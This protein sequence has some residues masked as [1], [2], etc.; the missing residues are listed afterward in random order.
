METKEFIIG[1]HKLVV[2]ANSCCNLKFLDDLTPISERE[3][4]AVIDSI[5]V[6]YQSPHCPAHLRIE[7]DF[8]CEDLNADKLRYLFNALDKLFHGGR[9]L[10]RVRGEHKAEIWFHYEAFSSDTEEEQPCAKTI[11]SSNRDTK[12]KELLSVAFSINLNRFGDTA[13]CRETN[14]IRV[15]HK[16]EA[17]CQTCLHELA[18]LFWKIACKQAQGHNDKFLLFNHLVN[19]AHPGKFGY[20]DLETCAVAR[21]YKNLKKSRGAFRDP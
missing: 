21:K 1:I 6:F 9:L 13:R 15:R 20:Y 5:S 11:F 16:L 8:D 14:G 4:K 18:H 7:D 3:R 12:D 2:P 19:G 10:A 17:L